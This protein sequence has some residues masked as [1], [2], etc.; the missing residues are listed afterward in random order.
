M[1]R[2]KSFQ[3]HTC[4][5]TCEGNDRYTHFRH[6]EEGGQWFGCRACW[7]TKSWER[8]E[9]VSHPTH[10]TTGGVEC[11]DAIESAI[12]GITDPVEAYLTASAMKYLWRWKYKNGLEDLE[13]AQFFIS[14]LKVKLEKGKTA[15]GS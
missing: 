12:S 10:Y 2:E 7:E 6:V 8:E 9:K 11:I 15:P 1:T 13:K 14:R 3:C 5:K 4:G